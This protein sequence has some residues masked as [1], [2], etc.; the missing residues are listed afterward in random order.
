MNTEDRL[1]TKRDGFVENI[2][3]DK[4]LNFLK[5]LGKMN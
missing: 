4:I 1:V 5:A 3:F 2:S